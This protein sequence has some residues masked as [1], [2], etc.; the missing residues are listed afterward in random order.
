MK[1]EQKIRIVDVEDDDYTYVEVYVGDELVGSF[2]RDTN[3]DDAIGV[4]ET[5]KYKQEQLED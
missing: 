3:A 5:I 2:G 4:V 1:P